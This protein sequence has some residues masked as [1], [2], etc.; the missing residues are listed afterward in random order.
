MELLIVPAGI[1]LAALWFDRRAKKRERETEDRRT[2][3]QQEIEERRAR[4]QREI[5]ADRVRENAL[6]T[7][8]D[9]MTELIE[10][11]LRESGPDDP[12]RSI[13]RSRT[14]TV[15]SQLDGPRRGLVVSFLYES[16]L[17]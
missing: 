5:E 3:E 6:Q 14:L 9:G 7:Y 13:A 1:A 16:G 8:L 11:G 12:K 17:I 4:G 15:L 10:K 2:K